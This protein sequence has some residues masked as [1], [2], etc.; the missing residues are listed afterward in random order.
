MSEATD[1]FYVRSYKTRE[2]AETGYAEKDATIS[3]LENELHN[4]RSTT[5]DYQDALN[6][7]TELKQT[8][9]QAEPEA[10]F[11]KQFMERE[12][13]DPTED[14]EG[15]KNFMK[16]T[17]ESIP[18][19]VQEQLQVTQQ[20]QAQEATARQ[21][22][23]EYAQGAWEKFTEQN[24]DLKE[25]EDVVAAAVQKVPGYDPLRA[26]EYFPQVAEQARARLKEMGVTLA[27]NGGGSGDGSGDPART[28]PGGTGHPAGNGR[29]ATVGSFNPPVGGG[30]PGTTA[31][32][33]E[34]KPP[35]QDSGSTMGAMQAKLAKERGLAYA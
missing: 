27:P 29:E 22:Y 5:R 15:A 24:P 35:E 25:Y 9:A 17:F 12:M 10:T 33:S 23:Q 20:K 19:V 6:K 18:L 34:V 13:P 4:M 3:R 8:Q 32:G 1:E 28:G 2:E 31:T 16:E 14:P 21:Q 11:T 26:V 7:V 30:Q